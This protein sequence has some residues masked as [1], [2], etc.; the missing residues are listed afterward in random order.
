MSVRMLDVRM[1]ASRLGVG[2]TTIYRLIKSGQIKCKQTGPR[3]G[4]KIAEKEV[5]MIK[6]YGIP[7]PK[8]D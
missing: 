8:E 1:V 7:F 5:M 3:K 2:T 4:Y 6:R